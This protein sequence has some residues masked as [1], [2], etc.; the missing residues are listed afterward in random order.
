MSLDQAQKSQPEHQDVKILV[1][2]DDTA[3]CE[4][5]EAFL[6]NDGYSVRTMS[7][8]TLVANEVRSG[9]YHLL[10]LDLMMPKLSGVE[11]LEQVR[12]IDSDISV[13]IFT[14]APTLD[15]AV[16]TMKLSA[17]DYLKK[18][19]NPEEFRS[20]VSRVMRSKG[21]L[22]SPEENLHRAIGETIRS[23]RKERALTLKQLALRTGL[24]VSLL[25]QIE[26]AES[27]A[28]ISSLYKVATALDA[29]LHDLFGEF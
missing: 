23:L 7:N 11:V 12:K 21:L 8:P 6:T 3:I 26:R 10:V 13:V 29:H 15:S 16:A 25:S 2:D 17:V 20:V 27:S 14:G 18:P 24:S 4:F 19:F 5:M 1:V 9:G 28:S 22:R